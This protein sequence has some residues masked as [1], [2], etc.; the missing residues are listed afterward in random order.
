MLTWFKKHWRVIG[1]VGCAVVTPIVIVGNP[2]VGAVVAATCGAL[3]LSAAN[4][5]TTPKTGEN[6]SK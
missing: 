6:K 1:S 3:G 4:Q 2:A 5:Y